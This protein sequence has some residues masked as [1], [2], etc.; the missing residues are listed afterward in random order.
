[1]PIV[2]PGKSTATIPSEHS[3]P[4]FPDLLFGITVDG[5]TVFDA[6]DYL[7]KAKPSASI[8]DFFEQYKAPIFSLVKSYEI[9]EDEVCMLAPNKHFI[10]D[11]NLVYLFISF[12]QPDFL[13]YMCDQ[14]QQMFTTGFCVSDTFIYNLAKHRLSK[15]VLEEI[16][17]GQV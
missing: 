11:G 4:E 16:I 5:T 13:A 2:I 10:V 14:M 1:M 17:N 9:K 6:T 15:G 12:I 8:T 3:F 7:Q